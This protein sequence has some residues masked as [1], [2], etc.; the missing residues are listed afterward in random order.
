MTKT[1]KRGGDIE[2]GAVWH[3][4]VFLS[5]IGLAYFRRYCG[6]ESD[7]FV[8]VCE[9]CV[10]TYAMYVCMYGS[11]EVYLMYVCMNI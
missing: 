6:P 9:Y 3:D 7:V 2:Y 1:V 4:L 11:M 8:C 10:W 5:E